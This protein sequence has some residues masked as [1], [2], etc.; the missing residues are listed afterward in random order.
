MEARMLA[1]SIAM[2]VWVNSASSCTQAWLGLQWVGEN[3][4]K[5]NFQVD[6][7]FLTP[8]VALIADLTPTHHDPVPRKHHGCLPEEGETSHPGPL[9]SSPT[10]CS[11][12]SPVCSSHSIGWTGC[13]Y[14]VA[15]EPGSHFPQQ[16]LTHCVGLQARVS[17]HGA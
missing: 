5:N 10:R 12:L 4:T 14:M 15:A 7:C 13:L 16:D 3:Y 17:L 1:L 8:C 2:S 11:L 9:H 6:L